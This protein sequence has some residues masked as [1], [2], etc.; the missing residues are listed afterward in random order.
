MKSIQTSPLAKSL[1]PIAARLDLAQDW[2][3]KEVLRLIAQIQK[4]QA[5]QKL[6]RVRLE[7]RRA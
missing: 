4:R 1:P 7:P 5:I 2:G 6:K 3:R